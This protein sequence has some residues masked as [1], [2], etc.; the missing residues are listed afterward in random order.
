[1]NALKL[2]IAAGVCLLLSDCN[3]VCSDIDTGE[4]AVANVLPLLFDSE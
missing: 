4:R 2:L 3:F 1:M